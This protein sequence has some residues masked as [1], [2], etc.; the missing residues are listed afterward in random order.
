L[1]NSA[2]QN[3]RVAFNPGLTIVSRALA[4]VAAMSRRLGAP[5]LV[6]LLTFAVF[7]PS[8]WYGFVN[9]DDP[10]NFLDNDAYRGLGWTHLRWMVTTSLMGQWIPLT[11]LTFG[12]NY[13]LWGM[14]PFGYHLTNVLLHCA[15]AVAWYFVAGRL[16]ALSM[17]SA[18]PWMLTAGSLAATLFFAIHPLRAESVAWITERRD[19]LSGVWF[20]MAVLGYLRAHEGGRRRRVWL[21]L[22][23]ACYT[24][25]ALSKSIVVSLPLVLLLLDIYPLRRIARP[26]RLSVALALLREKWLY[27]LVASATAVMA[28]WAQQSNNFLTSTETLPLVARIPVV[29]YSV[30]FYFAKTLVPIGLSPLHELPRVVDWLDARFLGAALGSLLMGAA[31]VVLGQRCSGIPVAWITYLVLLAPVSGVLHN[32]YQLVHDRYSYLSCLPWAILFGAG[33]ATVLEAGKRGLVRRPVVQ[34]AAC[35]TVAWLA[36]LG[37]L[38]AQQTQ[39][40][41]DDDTLWR[42]ALDADPGCSICHGNFGISLLTRGFTTLAIEEFQQALALRPDRLQ[43]RSQLGIALTRAGRFDAALAEF[44]RVLALDSNDLNTRNNLAVCLLRSGQTTEALA[45]LRTILDQDP[46]HVLA[47]A[48]LGAALIANDRVAE[49]VATLERLVADKPNYLSPRADLV[50]GYLALG[51]PDDAE[52]ALRALRALDARLAYHLDALF[53]TTW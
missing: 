38:A 51:R 26:W 24:L 23:A 10:V 44:R 9:W 18:A 36:A 40:W 41:R 35:T 5:L 22:S 39:V 2:E 47:R 12:V 37:A 11:W 52:R 4:R 31:A 30:W 25:A 33:V 13:V 28:I 8:L 7:A 19:V 43:V 1:L 14:D 29:L 27:F 16:L 48:N 21:L 15:A 53:I 42:Y 3:A 34:V 17:P 20:M 49:G 46:R 45:E 6:A 32:G 50:R